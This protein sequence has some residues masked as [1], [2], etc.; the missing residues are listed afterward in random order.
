MQNDTGAPSQKPKLGLMALILMIFTSVFG[1]T[2]I[3][4]SFYLMGYAS[5]PWYILAAF[6]FFLPF[7][8]MMAEFGAAFK[9]SRGGI[10][11]WMAKSVNPKFAFIGIFMWYTS[12]L[13]WMV[14]V[15]SGIWIVL[16]NAIFGSDKTQSWSIF[17]LSSVASLG[18][19]AICWIL[20]LTFMSSRGLESIKKFTSV[21]G[22]AVALINIALLVVGITM[23]VLKGGNMLEPFNAAALAHSPNPKYTSLISILSFLVYAIFAYGGIE[24]LGGLVDETENA[25]VTFPRGVLI[26]AAVIAVGYSVGLFLIGS[27][28]NW[29]ALLSSDKVTMGNVSYMIMNNMGV[30]LALALGAA[31]STA[32][33]VGNWFARY[34][35]ISMFL[36]LTGGFFT[37]IYAPLKQ[38]IEGTPK[39]LWPEGWTNLNSHGIPQKAMWVQAIIVII[40]I[41]LVAFGGSGASKFFEILVA[42]TNVSMTLPYV[43]LALAYIGFKNKDHI[44][45]PFQGFNK[46]VGIIMAYVVVFTVTF[47]NVFTIIEP[48]IKNP[49]EG[50]Q[51][52]LY[53]V[54]GPV[55][56]GIIA[57]FLY[58]AYEKR[59]AA[60]PALAAEAQ[61][62]ADAEAPLEH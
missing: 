6:T 29:Q 50:M 62:Q 26:S 14:N 38:M 35:G 39:A 1:F 21:G 37:L 30:Q 61:A 7:A 20:F 60:N 22:S 48:A 45:K 5:I 42:M 25:A 18:V 4:R 28:T 16:S 40:M 23:I 24:V 3:P 17:G 52:T 11:S 58:R 53:S 32:V 59:V 57:Y 34:M 12:F 13:I 54:M 9:D 43:F 46:Q 19:L 56:F 33:N 15:S 41:A 55:V 2:N 10:Y 36:A 47:A 44:I 49:G 31:E 8:L 51:Q 27:F